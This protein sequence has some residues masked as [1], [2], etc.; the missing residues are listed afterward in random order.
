MTSE[1]DINEKNEGHQKKNQKSNIHNQERK[2]GAA[3]ERGGAGEKEEH[4]A[5]EKISG[6]SSTYERKRATK[7][8]I[9]TGIM[10]ISK[11]WMFCICTWRLHLRRREVENLHAA[12]GRLLTH[13]C[14][15]GK[16]GEWGWQ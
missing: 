13:A 11:S 9:R 1:S 4:L 15:I 3:V 16:E 14:A 5:A 2:A 6:E 7:N 12:A 8:D 10:A